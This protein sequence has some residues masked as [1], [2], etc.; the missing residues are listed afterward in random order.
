[1]LYCFGDLHFVQDRMK[2]LTDIV[3]PE[4]SKL[5]QAEM[6]EAWKKG[7]QHGRSCAVNLF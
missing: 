7:L 3:W 1:M 6:Q 4:I 5:A 2:E